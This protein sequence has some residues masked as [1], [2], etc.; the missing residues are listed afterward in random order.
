MDTNRLH[1]GSAIA[2]KIRANS[3]ALSAMWS[4]STP[5]RH[6][7]LDGLLPEAE[8]LALAEKFP[9]PNEL[10][11]RSTIREH[12]R[13]GV[14]I[15]R[16]DPC[17]GEYLFAFQHPEVVTAIADVTQ[18]KELEPDP[19]LYASGISIMGR[20]D[21]LNPHLDNSHDGM[22][23]R[24]RVLNLLYYVSPNWVLGNGGN[25][26]LWNPDVSVAQT[27]ISQFNRLVV[28]ETT[29]TSWHS[30]SKVISNQPRFCCSNYY[31]SRLPPVGKDYSHVTTFA[32]RPE[33][34]FRGLILKLD[35][36]ARNAIAKLFPQITRRTKHK[37]AED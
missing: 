12:K 13:V 33:E 22:G 36:T 35:G 7:I 17:V 25:L 10:M 26:E 29:P 18:L 24:Y 28:M 4:S 19:T 8:V 34:F 11:L 15:K 5:T 2:E 23:A 20:D 1:I 16:Y 31:F 6:F 9:D 37:I 27:V 21:F 30:V 3:R 14:E 32:G